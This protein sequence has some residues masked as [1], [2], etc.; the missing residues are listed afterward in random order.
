MRVRGWTAVFHSPLKRFT[1]HARTLVVRRMMIP[2]NHQ[3]EKMLNAPS[4]SM[5]VV[6]PPYLGLTVS[7]HAA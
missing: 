5:G 3:D 6:Q 4:M 2:L 7:S 1:E